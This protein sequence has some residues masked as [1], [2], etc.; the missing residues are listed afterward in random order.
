MDEH[1]FTEE[2]K[3]I[4]KPVRGFLDFKGGI[5]AR[6]PFLNN[7]QLDEVAALAASE[8]YALAIRKLKMP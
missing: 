7:E 1:V 8:E 2:S 3:A 6:K 5:K 4:V